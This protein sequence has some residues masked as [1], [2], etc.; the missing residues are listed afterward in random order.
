MLRNLV[1]KPV[2]MRY[3]SLFGCCKHGGHSCIDGSSTVVVALV[4]TGWCSL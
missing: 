1:R 4:K 3:G 2:M